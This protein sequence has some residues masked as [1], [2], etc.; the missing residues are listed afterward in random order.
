MKLIASALTRAPAMQSSPLP[1][2]SS[3][4]T[5]ICP[6]RISSRTRSKSI[7]DGD[8]SASAGLS[9]DWAEARATLDQQ[10]L[11]EPLDTH[12]AQRARLCHAAAGELGI[13]GE[14]GLRPDDHRIEAVAHLVNSAPRGFAGHPA[15]VAVRAGDPS[16]ERGGQL[17][18]HE[19]Q[20]GG[21]VLLEVR[22]ELAALGLE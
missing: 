17:Q 16:V 6:L 1:S 22:V 4:T 10:V 14:H 11:A 8:A 5:T 2:R 12:L 15:R 9:E 21:D 20:T 19:W 13:V 18:H 7:V 3:T